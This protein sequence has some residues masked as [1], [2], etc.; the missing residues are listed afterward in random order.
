MNRYSD[1]LTYDHIRDHYVTDYEMVLP[2]AYRYKAKYWYIKAPHLRWHRFDGPSDIIYDRKYWVFYEVDYTDS[3]YQWCEQ[4]GID[5]DDISE[6]DCLVMW[7]E[8]VDHND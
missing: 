1:T 8:I 4:K 3:V 2:I 5:P 6:M 7:S